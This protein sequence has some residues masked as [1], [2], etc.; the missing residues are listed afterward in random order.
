M[1]C[2]KIFL[3]NEAGRDDKEG[4]QKKREPGASEKEA[5][6]ASEINDRCDF[7]ALFFKLAVVAAPV[8]ILARLRLFCLVSLGG[9]IGLSA[10]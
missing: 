5:E 7:G 9:V 3:K 1:G 8:S 10:Y 6:H 2:A 4:A